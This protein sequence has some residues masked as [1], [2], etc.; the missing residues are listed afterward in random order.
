M[1]IKVLIFLG[2]FLFLGT[3]FAFRADAETNGEKKVIRVGISNQN[4]STYLHSD[5]RFMSDDYIVI[6]DMTNAT[7]FQ[8]FGKNKIVEV[9]MTNGLFN[10]YYDNRLIYEK[11][12]GPLLLSSNAQLQLLNL[13][14]KGSPARYDGMFELRLA[15]DN[16]HFH[17]INILDSTSY[18]KGVVPNEM[19]ISFGFEALKAQSI[20]A[21][22]FAQN[23]SISPFYDVVDSTSSQVYYGAN[24][25]RDISNRAVNET[26]GIYALYNDKPISALYFSTSPGIT[27][28]W[29]DVFGN[30]V[31]TN[32]YPYL[33]ASYDKGGQ[34][35][36]KT[37]D[38]VRNFYSSMEGGIDRNSPKYRWEVVFERSELEEV[39]NKTL[40]EQSR[41]NLVFPKF[42]P[43]KKLEGLKEIRAIK[44][45]QSGKIIELKIFSKTGDYVVKKELG[46]RRVLKKNN[47]MLPSAN[48][49]VDSFGETNLEKATAPNRTLSNTSNQTN[50]PIQ[51]VLN[52]NDQV[53]PTGAPIPEKIFKVDEK[54]LEDISNK[55]TSE[56]NSVTE[57][58]EKFFPKIDTEKYPERFRLVGGGFGHG[59]GMSQF[60]AYNMAKMGKKYPDILKHYYKNISIS[61][62]PK[63]VYFNEYNVW[64]KTE[65]FFDKSVFNS[66]YLFIDNKQ[67]VSEF[68]FVVNGYE[69]SDTKP[70]SKNKLNKMDITPYLH[71]GVNSVNFAPLTKE[72]KG[73]TVQYRIEFL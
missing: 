15:K 69:F 5:V 12:P 22:N 50:T 61:T 35:A 57:K 2:L 28:D 24:S 19:P 55:K 45:T 53:K 11:L 36:L 16:Q 52:N 30:G 44:R 6:T 4:F 37:E 38:D 66:A 27:D 65:F 8:Q 9:T 58:V 59:V 17:I 54:P 3:L 20:A 25:Y 71:Q 48:F 72:N 70:A 33:K 13:D 32:T 7:K 41:A 46:I 42:D 40:A 64:Y 10:I 73:K 47:A 1:R 31:K 26:L 29:D 14:R 49:F 23:A 67:D 60:G 63:I 68:P 43:N 51:A 56:N 34:K 18:L 21:K 62:L 39:L